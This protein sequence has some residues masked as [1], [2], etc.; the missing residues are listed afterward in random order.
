M[1]FSYCVLFW[2]TKGCGTDANSDPDLAHGVGE[3]CDDDNGMS[4]WLA[5]IVNM[6]YL[7][8]T[9]FALRTRFSVGMKV[10]EYRI[11]IAR[12]VRS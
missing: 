1:Q 8:P 6:E 2:D 4:V 11:S 3:S 9:N 10:S 7:R 5:G 12:F